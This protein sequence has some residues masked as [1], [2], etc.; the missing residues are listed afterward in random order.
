MA[1]ELI[2]A[3]AVFYEIPK[4]G[5]TF[6]REALTS[7]GVAWRDAPHI[8]GVCP[9]HSLPQ[10]YL[11]NFAY[12]FCSVRHPLTWYESYFHNHV[13][14]K[15]KKAV[16]FS[17][18][19]WYWHAALGEETGEDFNAWMRWCVEHEPAFVTRVY[20]AFC[21]PFGRNEL[22]CAL[23]R[24]DLAAGLARV[25]RELGYGDFH[26][27]LRKFP[28][29]NRSESLPAAWDESIKS[30]V[31]ELERPAIERFYS[32]EKNMKVELGGGP[33]PRAGYVN[34]DRLP[35]ADVQHDLES[36]VLPFESDSVTDLYSA[37]CLEHV[38]NHVAILREVLRV[39]KIG[40][41]VE[42]RFPHWLHP[43]AMCPGHM[44]VL[45]D[46]QVELWCEFP[47]RFWPGST[48][49]FA[50]AHRHYQIDVDYHKLR[51]KFPQLSDEEAARFIPGCC[52]E[53]RY[54]LQVAE[55]KR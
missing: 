24:E 46:R 49:R 42:F 33:T 17:P 15:R 29:V 5:T 31:L 43:M 16:V 55:W 48:K 51:A 32:R 38:T 41:Q 10:H 34:L 4:T 52:H 6:M 50:M 40:A 20:E 28:P 36:G 26:E 9:R 19:T 30:R 27:E 44:H 53:V 1:I 11:G 23:R 18:G 21:G 39:C 8:A 54:R 47:E 25:L 22:D 7:L 45:S 2:K 12:R 37:H 35:S 13:R 3:N 14:E